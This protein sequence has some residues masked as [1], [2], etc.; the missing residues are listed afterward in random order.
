MNPLAYNPIS[1]LFNVIRSGNPMQI[2]QNMLS[3]DPAVQAM[4]KS[5]QN[6]CGSGDPKEFVLNICKERGLDIDQV[7]SA[8]QM[9]GL[10]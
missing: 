2:A 8:A 3:Q 9:L 1:A 5:C 4:L 7:M 10:K 6:Q